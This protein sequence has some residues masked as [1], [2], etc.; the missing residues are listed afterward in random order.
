MA[1]LEQEKAKTLALLKKGYTGKSYADLSKGYRRD[2]PVAEPLAAPAPVEEWSKTTPAEDF[3]NLPLV[4]GTFN[5]ASAPIGALSNL[6]VGAFDPTAKGTNTAEQFGAGASDFYKQHPLA[7]IGTLGL[8]NVIGGLSNVGQQAKTGEDVVKASYALGLRARGIDDQTA[9]QL[10]EQMAKEHPTLVGA[11]GLAWNLGADPVNFITGGESAVAKSLTRGAQDEAL[12]I[13]QEAGINT[14]RKT[15]VQDVPE[16]VYQQTVNRYKGNEALGQLPVLQKGTQQAEDR[17]A[18]LAEI[19]K[20]KVASQIE[21]KAKE[22]ARQTQNSILSL[23]IP[24]TNKV[25]NIGEKA[26]IPV[27]GKYLTKTP[28]L[29]GTQNAH[30]V[31]KMFENIEPTVKNVYTKDIN[32]VVQSTKEIVATP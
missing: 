27:V 32:G 24:F 16:Q 26:N 18:K 15:A 10:A 5:V 28:D 2:L 14:T 4:R 29:L 1:S 12:R 6:A 13:A 9:S 30:L 22:A 11:G 17:I 23:N 3:L 21:A 25:K 19:N 31:R 20:A 7:S 8:G